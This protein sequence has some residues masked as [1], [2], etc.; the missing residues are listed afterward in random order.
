MR[1]KG[2]RSSTLGVLKEK[3]KK[4]NAELANGRLAMMAIIGMHLFLITHAAL[5]SSLLVE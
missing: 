1:F 5:V 3:Q 2:F 4:L